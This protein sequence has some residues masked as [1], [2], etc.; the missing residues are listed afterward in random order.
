M[1]TPHAPAERAPFAK[2][3][4]L[5]DGHQLVI[6]MAPLEAIPQLTMLTSFRGIQA[7]TQMTLNQSGSA[8]IET[9]QRA[10]EA[11][12]A[13]FG[14]EQAQRIFRLLVTSI[15]EKAPALAALQHVRATLFESEAPFAK[16]LNQNQ[17]TAV[18]IRE[19]QE[20]LAFLKVITRE[21]E[22]KLPF[23]TKGDRDWVFSSKDLLERCL[24]KETPAGPGLGD[25]G[26]SK[27]RKP[28][29][30]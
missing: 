6:Y 11:L 12:L 9:Q 18:V 24:P 14:E 26:G 3:F 30:G 28:G 23:S 8:S 17:E 5:A 16:V 15:Q 4:E 13:E 25:Q 2:L 20:G 1:N 29:P 21:H 27:P 10:L 19:D 22:T 7:T